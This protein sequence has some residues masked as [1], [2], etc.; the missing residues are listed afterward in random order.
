MASLEFTLEE[1]LIFSINQAQRLIENDT[2]RVRE[3]FL[4]TGAWLLGKG[5]TSLPLQ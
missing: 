2:L 4:R 1:A 5:S 3:A